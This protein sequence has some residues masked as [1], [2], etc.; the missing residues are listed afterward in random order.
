MTPASMMAKPMG[1]KLD[2]ETSTS[3]TLVQGIRMGTYVTTLLLGGVVAMLSM[4]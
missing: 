4:M 1:A 3:A 2:P